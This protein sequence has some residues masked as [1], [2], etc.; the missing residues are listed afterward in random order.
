MHGSWR[1]ESASHVPVADR[2]RYYGEILGLEDK[3]TP[4]GVKRAFR[5]LVKQ[6][7]PDKVAQLGPKLKEAADEEIKKVN[8]AYEYFSREFGL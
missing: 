7:H 1:A 4:E 6:Y 8:E 3:I 5:E 2:R